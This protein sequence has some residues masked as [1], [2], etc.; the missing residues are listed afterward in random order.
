MVLERV[1]VCRALRPRCALGFTAWL[2]LQPPCMAAAAG[3]RM[4]SKFTV[5]S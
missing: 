5:P 2:L 1:A 4:G 3:L